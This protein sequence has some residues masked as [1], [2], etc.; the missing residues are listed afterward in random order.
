MG[1]S[2]ARDNKVFGSNTNNGKRF[3]MW[4]SSSNTSSKKE[5]EKLTKNPKPLCCLMGKKNDGGK[6]IQRWTRKWPSWTLV[7]LYHKPHRNQLRNKMVKSKM[8]D[9]G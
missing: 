7:G 9:G 6:K 4:A 3:Y 1:G 2:N 8:N 5:K